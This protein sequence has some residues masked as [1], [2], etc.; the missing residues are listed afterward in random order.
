[1]PYINISGKNIFYKEYGSGEPIIFLNGVMMSTNSWSPFIKT[2]SR[3]F[4]MVTVDLLDQGRSDSYE[5]DYTIDTQVEI[6]KVF[7]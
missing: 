6:L 2:L 1:M 7:R 3:D 5:D 4:K